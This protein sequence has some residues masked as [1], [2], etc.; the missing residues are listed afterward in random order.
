MRGL[1]QIVGRLYQ[2]G[3]RGGG[4]TDGRAVPGGK[5]CTI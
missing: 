2:M 3:G 4:I 1:Y 5:S